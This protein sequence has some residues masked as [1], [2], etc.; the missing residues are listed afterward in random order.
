M[1]VIMRV[2]IGYQSNSVQEQCMMSPQPSEKGFYCWVLQSSRAAPRETVLLTEQETDLY[3]F[4]TN[5]TEL[6][7]SDKDKMS[8]FSL[9]S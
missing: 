8:L 5:F 4:I 1:H 6:P 2:L 9:C 7:E 3:M